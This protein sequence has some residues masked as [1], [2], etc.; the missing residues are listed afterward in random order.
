MK[1]TIWKLFCVLSLIAFLGINL[2]AQTVTFKADPVCSNRDESLQFNGIDI[3]AETTFFEAYTAGITNI[4]NYVW[5]FDITDAA[6]KQTVNAPDFTVS[7]VY[8]GPGT[9]TA[10]VTVNYTVTENGAQVNKSESAIKDVI[11][12]AAPKVVFNFDSTNIYIGCAT[13][14]PI[15][16]SL[17]PQEA[18]INYLWSTGNVG[19]EIF[20]DAKDLGGANIERQFG[21]IVYNDHLCWTKSQLATVKFYNGPSVT[22]RANTDI[23]NWDNAAERIQLEA[24]SDLDIGGGVTYKWSPATGL[25]ADN[26]ANP[27]WR[28]ADFITEPHTAS[29]VGTIRVNGGEECRGNTATV[30]LR[31]IRK[32]GD[33]NTPINSN[34]VIVPGSARNAFW[35]I[36]EANWYKNGELFIYDRW[37]KEV[38][39][40]GDISTGSNEVWDGRTESG[41]ELPSDAY[42]YVIIV[43]AD[44]KEV[45]HTGSISV[46][47]MK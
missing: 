30:T 19:Q 35:V 36:Q 20:I 4:K 45:K 9:Y 27:S 41:K 11:V 39:H 10:R 32:G 15:K 8:N 40:K 12:Y 38:Y 34:N 37:G 14:K 22:A 21:A 46:L 7:H 29:V 26:I 18:D 28:P 2:K 42:Y 23:L 31:T 3:P 44:G 6:A 17:T 43:K 16:L 47:H 1:N 5:E 24:F 33:Y 25:N 13:G